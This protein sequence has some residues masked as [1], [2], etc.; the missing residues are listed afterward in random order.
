MVSL[1]VSQFTGAPS[2]LA[3]MRSPVA[4]FGSFLYTL[5]RLVNQRDEIALSPALS[6]R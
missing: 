3:G 1:L 4:F 5:S 2:F 6:S